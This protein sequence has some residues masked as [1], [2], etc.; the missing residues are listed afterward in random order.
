MKAAFSRTG[1]GQALGLGFM[2]ALVCASLIGLMFFE[3]MPK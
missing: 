1:L 3:S 2:M